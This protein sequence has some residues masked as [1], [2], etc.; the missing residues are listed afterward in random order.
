[1]GKHGPLSTSKLNCILDYGNKH[2]I[3]GER[4]QERQIGLLL[5]AFSIKREIIG[6]MARR[7]HALAA[8]NS[9]K[10]R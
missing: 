6:C 4:E 7:S 9:T 2:N 10:K 3:Q 8:K 5:F 1:M